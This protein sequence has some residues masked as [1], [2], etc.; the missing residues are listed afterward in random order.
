MKNYSFNIRIGFAEWLF[1]LGS[2]LFLLLAC[3]NEIVLKPKENIKSD[4]TI[5]FNFKAIPDNDYYRANTMGIYEVDI[6]LYLRPFQAINSNLPI[7]LVF[8]TNNFGLFV[9]KKDTLYPDD[10]T[11]LFLSDFQNFRKNGKFYTNIFGKQSLDFELEIGK[12]K[13]STKTSFE[14]K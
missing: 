6:E 13:K 10:Q 9:I 1:M 8:K 7:S 14:T 2:C 12:T 5:N 4:S 3:N 11:K